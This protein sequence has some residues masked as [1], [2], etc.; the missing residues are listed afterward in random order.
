MK[1][2]DENIN[3][4]AYNQNSGMILKFI[5]KEVDVRMRIK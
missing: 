4:G 1:Y 5:L 2:T 3:M